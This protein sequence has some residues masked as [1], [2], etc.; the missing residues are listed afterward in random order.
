MKIIAITGM[1]GSG[2]SLVQGVCDS[3]HIA[4]VSMGDVVRRETTKRGLELN[5]ENVGNTA[6]KL[7]ELYGAEAVAVPCIN[8]VNE[9]EAKNKENTHIIAVEGVRSI[10][11]L[12][13]FKRYYDV[14]VLAIHASPKTRFERLRSRGRE[15]DSTE[16]DV[17][18]ERDNR[19][20]DFTI[21]SV[22]ALA[23]YMVINEG[24]YSDVLNNVEN[25]FDNLLE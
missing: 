16:W 13:Y 4:Y 14:E 12:N 22:I 20:L 2:K 5:P 6:K 7:R 23:D 10:H 25:I 19:E 3:K 1:Q 11:E 8:L 9:V 21:G 24:T 18:I 15:D 17:F